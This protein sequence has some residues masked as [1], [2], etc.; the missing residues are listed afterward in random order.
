MERKVGIIIV[1]FNG[2]QL[3]AECLE[4]LKR[5]SHGA[6][7]IMV[8]DNG[9][10]DGSVDMI[11][12]GFP[13]AVCIETGENLGFAR[14]NNVGIRASLDDP[15]IRYLL[16]L[17]NDTEC[18]PSM[19]EVLIECLEKE[20]EVAAVGPKIYYFDEPDRIWSFGGNLKYRETVTREI[21][22][23]RFDRGQFDR[24]RDVDFITSCCMLISRKAL[25]E[26]GLLDPNYFINVDDA[27]WCTRARRAG[28]R[29]LFTPKTKIW[30]KVAM[31][32]GG[33]YKPF[34][35]F[36]T[37]RSNAIYVRKFGKPLQRFSFLCF[38]GF[39]LIAA[40]FR[41]VLRGGAPAVFAKAKG[42]YRGLTDPLLELEKTTGAERTAK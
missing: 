26:V 8:V 39:G 35:T 22:K 9:S 36:H 24:E 23:G 31:S 6:I 32:T 18:D 37:G 7:S 10:T 14:G 25:E 41:E 4:D 27:D 38:A 19:L 11:K 5:Q 15:D 12:T 34:K 21:G 1:N 33:S 16:L 28:Y 29:I 20:P 13:T 3:T 2:G 30:H 42:I 17:N 40:F